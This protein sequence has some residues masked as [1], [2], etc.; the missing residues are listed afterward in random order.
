MEYRKGMTI[1]EYYIANKD[2]LQQI[3][4]SSDIVVRSMALAVISLASEPEQ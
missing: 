4:Q 1:K 2:R 3:S